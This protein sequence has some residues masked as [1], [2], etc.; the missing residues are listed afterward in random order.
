MP[1]KIWFLVHIKLGLLAEEN[2][3]VGRRKSR[4]ATPVSRQLWA[5]AQKT[6]A[7][8][9]LTEVLDL[10]QKRENSLTSRRKKFLVRLICHLYHL[11]THCLT[12]SHQCMFLKTIQIPVI[13]TK[14][15][16]KNFLHPP[17]NLM[18]LVLLSQHCFCVRGVVLYELWVLS[19]RP[20]GGCLP[21]GVHCVQRLTSQVWIWLRGC[22]AGCCLGASI[23]YSVCWVG[24]WWARQ[25]G[26]CVS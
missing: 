10:C 7:L 3:H 23:F 19:G 13:L 18:F 24:P 20:D 22:C 17:R 4:T 1:L 9:F 21:A 15:I 26:P 5:L 8:H 6:L 12:T 14:A 25:R 2:V 16:I 11:T